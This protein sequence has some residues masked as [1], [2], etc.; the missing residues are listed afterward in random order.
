MARKSVVMRHE[1]A[2]L[3]EIRRSIGEKTVKDLPLQP[4]LP[5]FWHIEPIA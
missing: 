3:V 4:F 5:E 2:D 1:K